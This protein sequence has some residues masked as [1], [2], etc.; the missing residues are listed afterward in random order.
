MKRSSAALIFCLLCALAFGGMGCTTL[1]TGDPGHPLVSVEIHNSS[2]AQIALVTRQAFEEAGFTT[3]KAEPSDMRFEKPGTGWNTLFRGDWSNGDGVWVRAKCKVE[4]LSGTN[5][6]LNCTAGYVVD[7]GD[8]R[9]E[10]E[11]PFTSWKDGPYKKLMKT[12]KARIETSR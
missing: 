5:Y 8:P 12:I 1:T 4:V 3:Q 2:E 10:I 9:F 11:K 6:V 7:R